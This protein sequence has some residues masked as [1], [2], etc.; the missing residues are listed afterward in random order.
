MQQIP[1]RA[2]IER[3]HGDA[4][5]RTNLTDAEAHFLLTLAEHCL[6]QLSEMDWLDEFTFDAVTQF[7]RSVNGIRG[8][9]RT[10]PGKAVSGGAL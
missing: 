9:A 8:I 1:T 6:I 7:V 2:A 5:L 4:L 3:L 10:D